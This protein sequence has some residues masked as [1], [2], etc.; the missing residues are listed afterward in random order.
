MQAKDLIHVPHCYEKRDCYATNEKMKYEKHAM[1]E[2]RANNANYVRHYR[3]YENC[4]NYENY[5]IYAMSVNDEPQR[6]L[7]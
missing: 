7:E 1:Y 5:E 6:P 4:E 3:N 2:K